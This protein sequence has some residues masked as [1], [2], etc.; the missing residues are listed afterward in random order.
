VDLGLLDQ[1][2]RT[3]LT[4][5]SHAEVMASRVPGATAATVRADIARRFG[6]AL[7]ANPLER[8]AWAGFFSEEAV[9]QVG[10]LM[11]LV[12]ARL[13]RKL[14]LE[15]GERDMI[16]LH[17]EFEAEYP[18]GSRK[19]LQSTLVAF[20]EPGGD[21]AMA[22]TVSLPCAVATNLL[23]E[24]RIELQGV[25]I[26]VQPA[27]YEPVLAELETLDIRCEEREVPA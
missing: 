18:D 26:P 3:D 7:E 17:H 4:G 5:R 19:H 11:E 13:E 12:G 1:T 14:S 23:L 2:P 6:L 15:P 27:L 20:G 25:H 9:P 8:L 21:S 24:G 16:A 10:S 22:R